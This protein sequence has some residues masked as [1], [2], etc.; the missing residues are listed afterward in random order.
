[1]EKI[2]VIKYKD[3]KLKSPILIGGLPGIGNV[4]KIAADYIVE[5][6]NMT[7]MYDIFS[8]YLPPQVFIN[9]DSVVHL[10]R[11][12]IYYKK[13][14]GKH[15]L[16]I[17]AGDFQGTTQEA[18]YELSYQVLQIAKEIGV[19][20]IYTLGGY[21]IGKIVDKPR[22]LG[23]VTDKNLVADLEKNGVVFPKGE[24]GGGIVGSAGLIL[25][26][27]M[28]LFNMN[29]ACLMG[30]TSGYFADPKSAMEVLNVLQRQLG[31]KIDMSD[32]ETRS[33]QIEQIT[34]KMAEE[35]QN[36]QNKEDL[37]YFG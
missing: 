35:F 13:M 14:R 19:S 34:G 29:G 4:G 31:I 18:Q 12:S 30:E 27:G 16:V 10:V 25:G 17:L 28:E 2:V 21:S 32:I 15:D 23:A 8:Q 37:G 3:I 36:K 5:K 33:K 26:L 1:M 22:V 7:K 6:L 11:N 20:M 9:D 24:P